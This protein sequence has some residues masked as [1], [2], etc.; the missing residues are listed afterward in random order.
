ML[1]QWALGPE[2]ELVP[3]LTLAFHLESFADSASFDVGNVGRAVA[4]VGALVAVPLPVPVPVPVVVAVVVV[5]ATM[6]LVAAVAAGVAASAG[7]AVAVEANVGDGDVVSVVDALKWTKHFRLKI[8]D[9]IHWKSSTNALTYVHM[10]SEF[11]LV[12]R[13]GPVAVAIVAV[14]VCVPVAI[15]PA[16]GMLDSEFPLPLHLAAVASCWA[17]IAVASNACQP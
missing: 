7:E 8:N 11:E 14:A 3:V 17:N 13:V 6:V 5:D 4:F 2:Q 16:V 12:A 1:L 9:R 10:E 15:A